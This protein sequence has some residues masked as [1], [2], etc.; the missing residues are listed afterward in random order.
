MF[1]GGGF[2]FPWGRIEVSLEFLGEPW[3][4]LGRL[5]VPFGCFEILREAWSDLG[6]LEEAR[7]F[8]RFLGFLWKAWFHGGGLRFLGGVLDSLGR[9]GVLWGELMFLRVLWVSLGR[10]G[11]P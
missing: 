11:V 4:S 1:H 2:W 8:L 5:G 6:F 10:L 9:L 7:G 3:C